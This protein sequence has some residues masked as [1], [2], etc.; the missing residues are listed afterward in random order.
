MSYD[1][2]NDA[3]TAH[4]RLAI[5]HETRRSIS[6]A[7]ERAGPVRP[8]VAMAAPRDGVSTMILLINP[9]RLAGLSV[10][11]GPKTN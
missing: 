1:D 11:Y 6:T 7:A 4:L 8:R 2:V 10:G 5:S 3:M 9:A